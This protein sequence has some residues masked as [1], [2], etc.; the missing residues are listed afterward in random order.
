MYYY[1]TFIVKSESSEDEIYSTPSPEEEIE[2]RRQR[3]ERLQKEINISS[4]SN[5]L[6]DDYDAYEATPSSLGLA[7]VETKGKI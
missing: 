3:F 1:K 7:I 2:G 6:D 5:N 4:S